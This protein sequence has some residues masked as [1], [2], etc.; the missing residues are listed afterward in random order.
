MIELELMK[1]YSVATS[2]P[3]ALIPLALMSDL[4]PTLLSLRRGLNQARGVPTANAGCEDIS[5]ISALLSTCLGRSPTKSEMAALCRLSVTTLQDLTL[6]ATTLEGQ[7]M[8]KD[9]LNG[10][11]AERVIAFFADGSVTS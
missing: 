10:E 6:K 8:L 11:F 5:G 4:Y 1:G 3:M 9:Q 7:A 2:S